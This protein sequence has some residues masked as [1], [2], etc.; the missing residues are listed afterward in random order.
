MDGLLLN[1]LMN[2]HYRKKKPGKASDTTSSESDVPGMPSDD[3]ATGFKDPVIFY[4]ELG[5]KEKSTDHDRYTHLEAETKLNSEE[6]ESVGSD[7]SYKFWW[8]D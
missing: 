5:S 6:T 8:G 3:G 4:A 1:E 2:I 7:L